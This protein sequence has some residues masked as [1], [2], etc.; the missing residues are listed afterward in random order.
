MLYAIDRMIRALDRAGKLAH[1]KGLIV[2]GFTE[3]KDNDIPFGFSVKEII[4]D[5]VKK[6]GYPV[7]FNFPAGHIQDNCALKLGDEIRV[8]TNQRLVHVKQ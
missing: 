8:D 4:H 1:L 2:G 6:Y 3:L 7:A 5:V